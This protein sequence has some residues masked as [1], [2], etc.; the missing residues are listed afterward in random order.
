M[1]DIAAVPI[2]PPMSKIENGAFA[3]DNNWMTI[4]NSPEKQDSATSASGVSGLIKTFF[5]LI[6]LHLTL[7][8]ETNLFHFNNTMI[9]VDEPF[10]FD[11]C[12]S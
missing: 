11:W 6:S 12:K 7:S 3:N 2:Y 9:L 5:P 1:K 10:P 8:M 4:S